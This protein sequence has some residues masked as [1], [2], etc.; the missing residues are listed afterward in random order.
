[1]RYFIAGALAALC[2]AELQ[3]Q[4]FGVEMGAPISKYG[5]KLI[6]E[7]PYYFEITVPDPNGEFESYAAFAT[8]E[9]GICKV[10]GI[11][12]T[13]HNDADGT[14]TKK[15]FDG[16]LSVLSEKYGEATKYD[17]LKSG[18]L[19][20][21]SQEWTWSI[22]KNERVLDAYWLIANGS[23]LPPAVQGIRLDANSVNPTDGAYISLSYEFSNFY[24]CK[25]IMDEKDN[26]GL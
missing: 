24:S 6:T 14:E 10:S 22:Y 26:S 11:G 1:M 2:S 5:G 21:K 25:R 20:D 15:A 17:Y 13:H 18:A 12:K 3:A 4:A 23:R 7:S 9:T 16:L 8:P 19:W